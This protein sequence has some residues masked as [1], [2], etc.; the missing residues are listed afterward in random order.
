MDLNIRF[1]FQAQHSSVTTVSLPT[2]MSSDKVTQ[3]GAVHV[4]FGCKIF[5]SYIGTTWLGDGPQSGSRV[6]G[7]HLTLTMINEVV[8]MSLVNI[9]F[10][11]W[12]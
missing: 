9:I 5:M 8:M 6:L 3:D 2:K 11:I 1:I 4:K 7:I 12:K 10:V